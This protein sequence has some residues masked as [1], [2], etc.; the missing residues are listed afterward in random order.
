MGDDFHQP[1]GEPSRKRLRTSH[2][3]D[4]CRARKIRCDGGTPCT[5]CATADQDCTYGA[6]SNSRGKNDLILE[7]ILRVEKFLHEIN[8]N[9]VSTQ[10]RS[11]ATATLRPCLTIAQSTG[12]QPDR[13]LSYVSPNAQ[14]GS[15]FSGSPHNEGNARRP[16]IIQEA[17]SESHPSNGYSFDNAVLDSMH[18]STTESILQWPHFD[19]FSS[20]RTD[21]TSIFHLEQSRSILPVRPNAMYPYVTIEDID[22]ILDSFENNLN[23]WY[24]TMS[25][26]QLQSIRAT[27]QAGVPSEDNV[28]ACLTLLT[29]A[30]GC[31]SQAIAGLGPGEVLTED[32]SRRRLMK[33]KMGDI[34][35][36]CALKKLY[37][38]HLHTNS[39]AAQCL[40]FAAMYFAFL[41]R[42]LQAWEFLSATAA[43]CLLLLSYPPNGGTPED[44]ER[45]R[46]IFWACYI[47]ESDYVAELSACP[48]SG[49]ARIESSV[50]LPGAYNTHSNN[51]QEEQSA[52]YFL[53]CISM[54]RLLN[55]VHQ[56]LYA[57]GTGAALDTSRFPPIVAELN[58]QL[59]EWRDVLPVA[60]EF[61]L[62][63]TPTRTDAGGFLRQRY[64]T[65]QGVIYRPYLMWILSGSQIGLDTWICSLSMSGAMLILLAACQVPTLKNL[66]DPKVLKMGNHLKEL[67]QE[68]RRLDVGSDSPSVDQSLWI[69]HEADRFIKE[70]YKPGLSTFGINFIMLDYDHI[71]LIIAFILSIGFPPR[72]CRRP[73]WLRTPSVTYKTV[74]Q[75][76]AKVSTWLFTIIESY[77]DQVDLH[78]SIY[79]A[80][81]K[82]A[83][84]PVLEIGRDGLDDVPVPGSS[85]SKE[86]KK[87]ML[88]YWLIDGEEL[89]PEGGLAL[90]DVIESVESNATAIQGAPE[91]M[92]NLDHEYTD[93][94]FLLRDTKLESQSSEDKKA[95]SQQPD[96]LKFT[97]QPPDHLPK[98]DY[99]QNVT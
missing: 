42:P 95:K 11:S 65:C 53:A 43:K 74:S 40:F 64:L 44:Q 33:R 24:P 61:S 7:G 46:R 27:L 98:D 28:E 12:S 45:V 20:L 71:T 82:E 89:L 31:A 14:F 77:P 52:L 73:P 68:W 58:H 26:D 23:F 60:F 66:I 84:I 76:T 21:H 19:V 25:Q 92:I 17:L 91:M 70:G 3:C 56:L 86:W 75:N 18:T 47:L 57:R 67:F 1:S 93:A 41:V 30:L 22:S 48:P 72:P 81:M 90:S 59:D 83:K 97:Y 2:A 94:A 96:D 51:D 36:E 79:Q 29:M 78:K 63:T 6:E 8:A 55:R 87:L 69:I 15:S 39:V 88:K 4:S 37:V 50:S 85:T 35:F 13:R 5:T 32:E 16:S 99:E 62:D 38:A 10:L 49:I 9:L 80:M 34:Y 54:R